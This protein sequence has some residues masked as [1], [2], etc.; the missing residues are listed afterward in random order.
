MEKVVALDRLEDETR[1]LASKL[2]QRPLLGFRAAKGF[3]LLR[4]FPILSG[5]DILR[6]KK[7]WLSQQY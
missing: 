1:A 4:H 6:F 7:I 2:M 3:L 5:F